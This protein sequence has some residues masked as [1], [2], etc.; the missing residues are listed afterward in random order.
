MKMELEKK[1]IALHA[2]FRIGINIENQV[3]KFYFTNLERV[4][5]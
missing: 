4:T 5:N 3:S 2:L 1:C